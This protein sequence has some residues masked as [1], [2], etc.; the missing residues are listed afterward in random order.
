MISCLEKLDLQRSEL[1]K[2]VLLPVAMILFLC[3]A[4]TSPDLT[5]RANPSEQTVTVR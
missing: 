1:Q 4:S 5:W 3:A 2:L